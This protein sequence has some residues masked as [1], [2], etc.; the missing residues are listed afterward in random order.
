MD[1]AE[2]ERQRAIY[3]ITSSLEGKI[4]TKTN[5]FGL[6]K[7]P[8]TWISTMGEHTKK[9]TDFYQ[10]SVMP[11]QEGMNQIKQLGASMGLD[12]IGQIFTD[13]QKTTT[14][15]LMKDLDPDQSEFTSSEE[16]KE[17]PKPKRGNVFAI[18]SD[19][20]ELSPSTHMQG[21][22]KEDVK[23]Y[24]D[25]NE[26]EKRVKISRRSLGTSD[27]TD[28]DDEMEFEQV[29]ISSEVSP[30]FDQTNLSFSI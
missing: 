22:T 20:E 14:S 13:T 28:E 5:F 30:T 19:E 1:E 8:N 23:E 21:P 15:K 16:Q 10:K 24:L 12:Q 6:D 3:A 4:E 2:I 17:G 9:I 26:S 27:K 25:Q 29:Q 18:D 7:I 11:N